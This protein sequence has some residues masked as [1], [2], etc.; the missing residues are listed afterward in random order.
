MLG[1]CRCL[2]DT[3]ATSPLSFAGKLLRELGAVSDLWAKPV[4]D[5]DGDDNDARQSAEDCRRV[6]DGRVWE[7]TDVVVQR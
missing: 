7:V 5:V 3:A 4:E 6:V 2:G 1:R